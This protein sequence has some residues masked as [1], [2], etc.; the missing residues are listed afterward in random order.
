[1]SG[2]RCP[3][4]RKRF[5]QQGPYIFETFEMVVI[6]DD[7]CQFFFSGVSKDHEIKPPVL[8]LRLMIHCIIKQKAVTEVNRINALH[9]HH[10]LFTVPDG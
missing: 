4:C 6:D 2:R 1:M 9:F 5:F 8:Q 10:M 7:G 3:A